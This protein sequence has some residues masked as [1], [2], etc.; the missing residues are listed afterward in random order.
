[1]RPFEREP[2]IPRATNSARAVITFVAGVYLLASGAVGAYFLERRLRP[3]RKLLTEDDRS[4]AHSLAQAQGARLDTVEIGSADG[5]TL[6]AWFFRLDRQNQAGSAAILFHGVADSRAGMMPYAELLLRNGMTVLV[7]DARAHG[8][9]GGDLASYGVREAD[10]I[11]SWTSWLVEENNP[12]CIFALGESMGGA[13]LLQALATK[14]RFCAVAVESAFANFREVAYDYGG[15]PFGAGSWAGRIFLRPAI[16]LGIL[17]VWIRHGLNLGQ[18]SPEKAVAATSVPVLLIH[19]AL[20][21][22]IPPRHS[23]RLQARNPSAV[24]LW[25]VSG[26]GHSATLGVHPAEFERRVIGWFTHAAHLHEPS[27]P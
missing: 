8:E 3:P 10:D 18:A 11:Q 25:I 9:S 22:N 19:G 21:G 15:R 24:E 23:R 20:D 14:P 26:V 7:P 17:Y 5:I 1:L 4:K 13:L 6:Q 12:R 27:R 16:E 2:A